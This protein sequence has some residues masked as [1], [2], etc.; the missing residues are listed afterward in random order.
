MKKNKAEKQIPKDEKTKSRDWKKSRK[1][2]IGIVVVLIIAGGIGATIF[3]INSFTTEK[4]AKVAVLQVE[5]SITD[6]TPAHKIA[7]LTDEKSVRAVVIEF[8]SP[9]GGVSSSFQLESAISELSKEKSTAS[10]VD[11]LGASGAY[12]S[13]SAAENVYV[14]HSS[15]VG[16]IGVIA[17][18]KS[19]ENY[20]KEKG[21]KHYVFQTG[22]HKDMFAPWRSPTENEKEIIREEIYQIKN[23]MLSV[24]KQNRPSLENGLPE[25]VISGEIVR[26]F[27]AV[28]M[29][30]ADEIISQ[31]K[32]A[33]EKV[34]K[35]EGLEEG[36]YEVVTI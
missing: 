33:V 6:F 2:W 34:A 19:L 3:A 32:E 16:S 30:L 14:H 20:Y 31:R 25:K 1:L 26:G 4:K 17:I 35:R 15:R 11:Q 28:E 23:R 5:G 21:I 12:L 9:G 10:V 7:E 8:N 36:E 18:W 13:A 22:K 24:I 27:E 29:S